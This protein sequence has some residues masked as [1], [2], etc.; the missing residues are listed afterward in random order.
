MYYCNLCFWIDITIGFK[1]IL[2]PVQVLEDPRICHREW[3]TISAV[4]GNELGTSVLVVAIGGVTKRDEKT[5]PTTWPKVE[6]N[7][8]LE[9]SEHNCCVNLH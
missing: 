4:P 6:T 5:C 1:L 9:F 7:Y 2:A 3:H 8:I